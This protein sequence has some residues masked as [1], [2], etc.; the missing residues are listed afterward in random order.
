MMEEV[1][2]K[3]ADV[4]MNGKKTLEDKGTRNMKRYTIAQLRQMRETEDQVLM[5]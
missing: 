2:C 1:R 4:I 5:Y 3:M